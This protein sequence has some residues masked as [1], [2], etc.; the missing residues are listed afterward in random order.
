MDEVVV[1]IFTL[2]IHT[3]YLDWPLFSTIFLLCMIEASEV[4]RSAS[5]VV[6]C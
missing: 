3:K 1:V 4:D 6:G 2:N 5:Y